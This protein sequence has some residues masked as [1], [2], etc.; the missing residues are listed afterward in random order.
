MRRSDWRE[1]RGGITRSR[2]SPRGA[3]GARSRGGERGGERGLGKKKKKKEE[4]GEDGV[5]IG[6]RRFRVLHI[7]HVGPTT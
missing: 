1:G 2:V 5:W 6:S 3:C 4:G 7:G